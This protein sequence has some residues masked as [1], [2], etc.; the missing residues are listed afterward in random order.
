MT[1]DYRI[2]KSNDKILPDMGKDNRQLIQIL[3]N[4][5]YWSKPVKKTV[6][7]KNHE[8]T[9]EFLEFRDRYKTIKKN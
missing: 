4:K 6:T 9:N 2:T 1:I 8:P 7:K 3:D 5:M